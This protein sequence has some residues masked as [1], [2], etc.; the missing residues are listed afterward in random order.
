MW[1]GSHLGGLVVKED[2]ASGIQS[3]EVGMDILKE[4]ARHDGPVTLTGLSREVGLPPSTCRRYLVSLIRS[5]MVRQEGPSGKYD[6][7]P[8]LLRL[9][10]LGLSR[11]DMVRATIDQALQLNQEIDQ[12]T[13]VAVLGDRGPTVVAWFDS[14]RKIIVNSHIG[15]VYS[16]RT[17]ATGWIFLSYL[18]DDVVHELLQ[19]ERSDSTM[20]GATT[21]SLDEVVEQVR[22]KTY[23]LIIDGVVPGLSAAAAPVFDAQGKLIAAMTIMGRSID[24]RAGKHEAPVQ[25]LCAAAT[26]VSRENGFASP[27]DGRS[28]A[29]WLAN[30]WRGPKP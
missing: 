9:G 13:L 17:T 30:V 10:L 3:F 23:A 28:Y 7:G 18:P 19:A 21:H 27:E 24:Y 22:S 8:D 25:A 1:F 5:G 26:Q 4:L 20:D 14:R 29:T 11:W 16:L 15:S 2:K 6:V 12:T